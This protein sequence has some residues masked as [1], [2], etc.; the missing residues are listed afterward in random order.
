MI[1]SRLTRIDS[2][3]HEICQIVTVMRQN[4][5]PFYGSLRDWAVTQ[6]AIIQRQQQQGSRGGHYGDGGRF[7]GQLVASAENSNYW[8]DTQVEVSLAGSEAPA[9][10]TSGARASASEALTDNKPAALPPWMVNTTGA[11]AASTSQEDV[12]DTKGGDAAAEVEANRVAYVTQ[13]MAMLA[14][15]QAE[16]Q[17]QMRQVRQVVRGAVIIDHRSTW[18]SCDCLDMWNLE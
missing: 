7:S 17:E 18:R 13:Y 6:Q 12:K 9:A 2:Q 8:Q 14:Q 11:V 1:A 15:V 3:L 16:K 5:P 10:E 4:N